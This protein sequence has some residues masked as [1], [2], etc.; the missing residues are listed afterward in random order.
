MEQL[1]A[2][3][4]GAA[5]VLSCQEAGHADHK[6]RRRVDLNLYRSDPRSQTIRLREGV[7]PLY[8]QAPGTYRHIRTHVRTCAR[9][10]R[11]ATLHMYGTSQAGSHRL[12]FIPTSAHCVPTWS[13]KRIAAGARRCVSYRIP[14]PP[15]SGSESQRLGYRM[16]LSHSPSIEP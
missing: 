9:P 3:Y 4:G 14:W 5:H 15:A 1:R 16:R 8:L 10:L 11:A 12:K 2:C 13:R 6:L 7:S